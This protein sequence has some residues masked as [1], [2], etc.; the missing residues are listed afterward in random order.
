MSRRCAV[1]PAVDAKFNERAE[2]VRA[3]KGRGVRDNARFL[4]S[5]H[6]IPAQCWIFQIGWDRC[7]GYHVKRG[8]KGLRGKPGEGLLH[9]ALV[10]GEEFFFL[11]PPLRLLYR[12][13]PVNMQGGIIKCD[14]VTKLI[15]VLGFDRS[16]APSEHRF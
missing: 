14:P 6:H 12:G 8:V 10:E 11:S 13:L 2:F 15:S 3:G 1:N 7:P 9:K 16:Q 4:A 5:K